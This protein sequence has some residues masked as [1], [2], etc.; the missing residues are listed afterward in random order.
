[1]S[2]LVESQGEDTHQRPTLSVSLGEMK[3]GRGAG[4]VCARVCLCVFVALGG[5]LGGEADLKLCL[6]SG[7]IWNPAHRSEERRVGK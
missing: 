5:E 7:T 2:A 1:M 6:V 4:A 3:E